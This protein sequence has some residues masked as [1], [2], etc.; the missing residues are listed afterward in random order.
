MVG[1]LGFCGAPGRLRPRL[2]HEDPR[3]PPEGEVFLRRI[4]GREM[5]GGPLGDPGVRVHG[6]RLGEVPAG[7]RR[8][9]DRPP[10]PVVDP[11]HSFW[12]PRTP[13]QSP[14]GVTHTDTDRHK[15]R[16]PK[17]QI[18]LYVYMHTHIDTHVN[19]DLLYPPS[20]RLGGFVISSVHIDTEGV[21]H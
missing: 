11:F 10:R 18:H 13:S 5:V 9:S 2:R 6:G 1:D 8:G 21:L 7:P 19:W 15:H 16:Y 4:H 20:P 3:G 17:D 14:K 12:V